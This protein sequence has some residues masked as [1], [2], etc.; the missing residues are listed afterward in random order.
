MTNAFDGDFKTVSFNGH[1]IR[2]DPEG[3]PA[4]ADLAVALGYRRNQFYM[5]RAKYKD[6]LEP[7]IGKY[8][9]DSRGPAAEVL[10]KEGVKLYLDFVSRQ[11]PEA[12]RL[13]RVLNAPI[14]EPSIEAS[15]ELGDIRDALAQALDFLERLPSVPV[16]L[17][18][19]FVELR[20]RL[21]RFQVDA[22]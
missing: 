18:E 2:I 11:T 7:H 4:A 17:A 13:A 9:F 5:M 20:K 22:S 16:E 8:R 15:D 14:K 3:R 1:D 12:H 19:D 10:S 21:R 6:R